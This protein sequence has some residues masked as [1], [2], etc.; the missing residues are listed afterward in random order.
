[1]LY[2]AFRGLFL[3]AL[4]IFS[5]A[6]VQ[7]AP[8]AA[9]VIDAKSGKVLFSRNADKR[10][11]PASLT[12]MMTLY[13]IFSAIERG[14]ISLNKQVKISRNAASKPPSKLGMRVGS[15]HKMRYL[16]RA[17][18]VKSAND[19][20]TALAEALSGSE[21]AFARRMTR[22]ARKLGMK[23]TVFKNS[24][25]LTQSG[26]ISTARDMTI[27]GKRLMNDFPQ[28]YNLF[29]RKTTDVGIKTVSN[30]NRRL[31]NNYA[32]ADGI[33]TGY[34]AAAGFNLVA[35]AKKGNKRV[36]ATVFGGKS[37]ADRYK[38]IVELLN[39]G[40]KRVN[41]TRKYVEEKPK[42]VKK[43]KSA[44]LKGNE[45]RKA[46][47][48]AAMKKKRAQKLVVDREK[49]L[50]AE[51]EIV[52]A[53]Q[54]KN[55]NL[56]LARSLLPRHR[57]QKLAVLVNDEESRKAK[58][59]KL[60]EKNQAVN[61]SNPIVVERIAASVN[62]KSWTVQLG[63]YGSRYAAEKVLL[64]TVLSDFR[65]LEGA[66]RQI[67]PTVVQGRQ[68]YRAQFVG[69]SKISAGKTCARLNARSEKCTPIR[70]GS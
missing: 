16:I 48:L 59:R 27:L 24:H 12:K 19:A 63:S 4:L 10:L 58:L 37:S 5:P 14:E 68:L 56:S 29:S 31:L 28:Y 39:I 67:K 52:L 30:T 15:K 57:P 66:L 43:K 32:G 26:H 1:M 9:M 18:A 41:T 54:E 64:R 11:H 49:E 53:V 23:R 17:T 35:S 36:I 51:K 34:T 55:N 47:Y 61:R 7:A 22:Q 70:S 46:L 50:A 13:V 21:A 3:V 40:F 20:A 65:S 62:N 6:F 42:E 69:I 60:K 44:T 25:G 8:Y 2:Q 33:K 45:R 38:K